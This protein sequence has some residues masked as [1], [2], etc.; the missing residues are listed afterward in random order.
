MAEKENLT[1]KLYLHAKTRIPGGVQL[2][3]KRP[4]N[5]AP[6]RWPAYFSRAEGCEVWDLDGKHYYDLS[7]NS[8]GACLLGYRDPDVTQAVI[9]R[10]ELGSMCTL[11]PPEEVELADLLCDIH[12]W[13]EQVRFVRGGGEACAVAVRIARA[14]T[15]RSV[16]A[17]CGYHGW[18]DWYLAANLGENDALRGHLLPGLSPLGVPVELRDT[19]VAF[20]YNDLASF[21]KVI[22]NYGSRLAAV[23]M[24]P[25]R[26]ADPEP[27][28][29]EYIREATRRCGALLIFDEITVGWRLHYGGA[30]LRFG[31]LPDIAVFAKAMGNGTPIGA[32]IGTKE[33]MN[34]AHDS[35]IS[36]TYWTES[37]GPVA[38]VATLR[39]MAIV[40]VPGHVANVGNGVMQ[41]WRR[42]A[43]KYQLPV[44][45]GGYPS[46]AHFSFQ[47]ED[48]EK[49]RTLYTQLML[50]RGFLAGL[51]VYPTLAHTNEIVQLYY[52]A[53]DE[54]FA[55]IGDAFHHGCVDRALHGRVAASGFARLI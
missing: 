14:S 4:E 38:A 3:S 21:K 1:E 22:E 34:G 54:V 13:A 8:V 53:I 45:T 17:I 29:L 43:E 46:L 12:P 15:D 6:G 50:D 18:S 28:F 47:H 32:V 49:L 44:I 31:V 20:R 5:M 9:R 25:C 42:A 27:G 16:I 11:N 23:I 35:F 24:E 30:H 39:K 41:Q 2:L 51:A 36:S 48:S 52:N 26:N 55:V 40:D 37:T 10:L 33:A 19:T 7:T